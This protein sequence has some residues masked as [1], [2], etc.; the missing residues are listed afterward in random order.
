MAQQFTTVNR[1][2]LTKMVIV[3]V[4]FIGFGLWGLYDATVAYPAQG[5]EAAQYHKWQYLKQAQADG[6]LSSL[7]TI[8]DP[9]AELE[10][11]SADLT[12]LKAKDMAK[13]QWLD[14]LRNAGH[15]TAQDVAIG[16]AAGELAT[17]ESTFAKRPPAKDLSRFDMLFQWVILAVGVGVG[18][19]MVVFIMMVKGQRFSYD[20][21]T[22]TLTLQDGSTL[23]LDDIEDFDRRKWDKFLM[24]IKVK[25]GKGPHGGKELKLDLLRF[26]PL[27][28][29]VVDMEY[30][31]FPDRK[32]P[33]APEA[34]ASATPPASV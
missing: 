13:Q 24:Y 2:W 1:S 33:E 8:P 19:V 5:L 6:S 27:E 10:R 29:W 20:T 16:N 11:L 25:D 31:K 32:E 21:E 12:S 26:V 17:L 30:T 3:A 15:L 23:T 9:A 28:D 14:Q 4:V 18:L 7:T 34:Q 22:K